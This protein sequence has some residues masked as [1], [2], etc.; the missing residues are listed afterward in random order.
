MSSGEVMP[1]VWQLS[2]VFS[3]VFLS[4]IV[5][6]NRPVTVQGAKRLDGQ[7]DFLTIM[8]PL[9]HE[10]ASR[11]SPDAVLQCNVTVCSG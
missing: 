3:V 6:P 9:V 10:T 1:L 11:T 2:V 5:S 8:P 4:T 7:S